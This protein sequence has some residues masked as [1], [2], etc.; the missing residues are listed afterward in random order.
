MSF[1]NKKESN[2]IDINTKSKSDVSIDKHHKK[3]MALL[4]ALLDRKGWNQRRLAKELHKDTTTVNRWAKNSRDI[5]WDQAEEIAK[6]IGCHP[7]EIY[8]PQKDITLRWYVDPSYEVKT[9]SEKEQTQIQIPFE[10]YHKNVR[11]IQVNVPGSYVDGE[12]LLVDIPQT[13]KF[14]SQA[15]GKYCYCT[16]SE[17]YKKK[18]KDAVDVIGILKSNDDYSLSV[19]NP[20]TWKPV[21]EACKSFKPED[22]GIATPVKVQY[23]PLYFGQQIND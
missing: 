15:I 7:V 18:N 14:S 21:N 6:V 4:K 9:Y 22:L 12:I 20:L 3:T 17:K 8:M 16:S 11:A 19:L 23:N 13:R 5:K 1:K 2:I 10:Y